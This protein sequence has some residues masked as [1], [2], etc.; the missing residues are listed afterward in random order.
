M[1]F[2]LTPWPGKRTSRLWRNEMLGFYFILYLCHTVAAGITWRIVEESKVGTLV[3]SLREVT[4][5]FKSYDLVTSS[6]ANT[7]SN[8]VYNKTTGNV[9][10]RQIIDSDVLPNQCI[11][12]SKVEKIQFISSTIGV[13][14]IYVDV[15]IDD[16]NDNRPKFASDLFTKTISEKDSKGS[17]VKIP[18]AQDIDCGSNSALQY[19]ILNSNNF[20]IGLTT[21][22][23][24]DIVSE[25]EL[26]R[27]LKEFH[28]L[29]I[30]A[31]DHGIPSKCSSA[32]INITVADYNDNKPTFHNLK[33]KVNVEEKCNA[34]SKFILALNVSDKDSGANGQ[35]TLS[36]PHLPEYSHHFDIISNNILV[37]T[38]CLTYKKNKQCIHVKINAVD[39]GVPEQRND[40]D[41]CIVVQD[42]NDHDP[43]LTSSNTKR[44]IYE[45]TIITDHVSI[46]TA[47][48]EDG[49]Q[50]AYV[51]LNIVAG[52]P[53]NK[54]YLRKNGHFFFLHLNGTLDREEMSVYNITIQG[55]DHGIPPRTSYISI[56]IPVLDQNDNHPSCSFPDAT[57][58]LKESSPIGTFVT[59][60]QIMDKDKGNNSEITY[61]LPDSSQSA[62][63][64][65]IA[66]S[67]LITTSAD[68]DYETQ[69]SITLQVKVED[70]GN[71]KLT[72]L[73]S[74]TINITDINDNNP[75]FTNTTFHF[76]VL[77]NTTVNSVVANVSSFDADTSKNSKLT[78]S[79]LSPSPVV[80]RTF[81]MNSD[82][83]AIQTLIALD[84]E[85]C[86]FYQFGVLVHD[87]GNPQLFSTATVNLAILDINDNKPVF[88]P[89]H[90]YI[91][92]HANKSDEFIVNVMAMDIDKNDAIL[93]KIVGQH[94]MNAL[95]EVN[96]KT[97]TVICNDMSQLNAN[98][99]FTV[100]LTAEDVEGHVSNISTLYVTVITTDNNLPYFETDLYSFN[101]VENIQHG[102]YVGEVKATSKIHGTD[103]SYSI[104][105]GDPDGIFFINEHGEIRTS[106]DVDHEKQSLFNLQVMGRTSGRRVLITLTSVVITVEDVNDNPP[107]FQYP[108]KLITV[109]S[110]APV[111][112]I[113]FKAR[114]LDPDSSDGGIVKYGLLHGSHQDF[115]VLPGGDIIV[116]NDLSCALN[117]SPIIRI[118]ASDSGLPQLSSVLNLT[119]NIIQEYG[120]LPIIHKN[121]GVIA[122][123]QTAP[124]NKVFFNMSD[125]NGCNDGHFYFYLLGSTKATDFFGIFPEGNLYVKQSLALTAQLDFS[126]QV[127]VRDKNNAKLNSTSFVQI[128]VVQVEHPQ[129]LFG[130]DV[131]Q[132]SV[133]ENEYPGTIVG[134]LDYV[135]KFQSLEVNFM[136]EH[137]YF[138]FDVATS[139]IKTK[140]HI[141]REQLIQ[142]MGCDNFVLFAKASYKNSL[143]FLVA[144]LAKIVVEV[145][146][147]NDNMPTC[148]ESNYMVN[149][150]E[151]Q[152]VGTVILELITS[153][154][155]ANQNSLVN[156]SIVNTSLPDAVTVVDGGM[157][158]LNKPLENKQIFYFNFSV[159]VMNIVLPYYA[160]TCFIEVKIH[161]VNNNKPKFSE[162]F[163]MR[164]VAENATIG[165]VIHHRNAVDND[166]GRNSRL[167]YTIIS[168]NQ[169]NNF[170]IDYESGQV[171]LA[172][173]LDFEKIQSYNLTILARDS[174]IWPLYNHQILIVNVTDVND[175]SPHFISCPSLLKLKENTPV[176]SVVLQCLA[177]DRDTG[178]NGIVHYS[179]SREKPTDSFFR[180]NNNGTLYINK[181]LDREQFPIYKVDITVEDGAMPKASRL[182]RTKTITIELEDVN[183]NSP[184]FISPSAAYFYESASTG[185]YVTTLKAWDPD[186]GMNGRF[187]FNKVSGKDAAFF[188]V[189]EN[190]RVTF[191]KQP[192]RILYQVNVLVTDNGA[193][194]KTSEQ[195]LSVFMYKDGDLS[196]LQNMYSVGIVENE[197]VGTFVVNV[198]AASKMDT[199]DNT[200][201]Q[202][203][204]TSDSSEGLLYLN[205]STGVITIKDKID[206]EGK[207]GHQINLVIYA[208]QANKSTSVN[209]SIVIFDL[210]DNIPTFT[211]YT[212]T[213]SIPENAKIGSAV[214]IVLAFDEDA[215]RNGSLVYDIVGGNSKRAFLISNVTGKISVASNLDREIQSMYILNVTATDNG[216]P[217]LSS[218]TIVSVNILDINDN[219]PSFQRLN[220]S[221]TVV[222]NSPFGTIIGQT[223][224]RDLDAGDNGQL[225]YSLNG[226]DANLFTVNAKTGTIRTAVS[227]DREKIDFYLFEIV[228][229]DKGIPKTLSTMSLVYVNVLDQNDNS[230]KFDLNRS[231]TATVPESSLVGTPIITVHASDDDVGLNSVLSYA[232]TGGDNDKSFR[233][234]AR[235]TLLT[236]SV[237][238]RENVAKYNIEVTVSDFANSPSN[239][240]SSK[241]TVTVNVADINDNTPYFVSEDV[242]HVRED[243]VLGQPFA[244]V[245]ARDKDAGL[246]GKIVYKLQGTQTYF[247]IDK[248]SGELGLAR[249]LDREKLETGYIN[250]TVEVKDRGQPPKR[251]Q[252]QVQ[253]IVDDVNDNTPTFQ[254]HLKALNVYENISIG[255]ELVRVTA[256]DK[257]LGPNGKVE[258]AITGGN[259]NNSFSI[260]PI[261][262]VVTLIKPLDRETL[263]NYQ[264]NITAFDFGSPV[265][266]NVTTVHIRILDV[267]DNEPRFKHSPSVK[268]VKENIPYVKTL[269]Q[270]VATDND[271]GQNSEVVYSILNSV[272]YPFFSIDNSTGVISLVAPLDREV[273]TTYLLLIE[274]RDKGNPPLYTQTELTITVKDENDNSPVFI[275]PYIK[276]SIVE[277][278]AVGS[279]LCV[280]NATDADDSNANAITYELDNDLGRFRIDS[281]TGEIF[282]TAVLDR[283]RDGTEFELTV[284]AT[285]SGSPPRKTSTT[286]IGLIEDVDDNRAKFES[287]TYSAYIP[288]S[289]LDGSFVTVVSAVDK[290]E[291]LN[292]KVIYK[293]E[294][295]SKEVRV[296]PYTGNVLMLRRPSFKK[297]AV[298]IHAVNAKSNILQ[299]T[300]TVDITTTNKHFPSFDIPVTV[301]NI[302]E[303]AKRGY[304][305][306]NVKATDN[307]SFQIA[308]GDPDKQF[309]LDIISKNLTLNKNLDY[310]KKRQYNLWLK[311]SLNTDYS[312]YIKIQIFVVDSN[313]N[314]PMFEHSHEDVSLIEND[315]KNVSVTCIVAEDRDSG[316]FGMVKYTILERTALNWFKID[317]RTGCIRTTRSI[318]REQNVSFDFT[319]QAQDHGLPAKANTV[320]VH[321]NIVDRNDNA[322]V[323]DKLSPIYISEDKLPPSRVATVFA[324]DRDETSELTYSLE[325]QGNFNDTFT[326]DKITGELFLMKQLDR[327]MIGR[328][329]LTA[330]VSDGTFS[331]STS[332]TVI[333]KDVDDNPPKFLK[334]FYQIK[335]MELQ[336]VGSLVLKLN[337][338]DKDIGQNSDVVYSLKRTPTS[339]IFRIDSSGAITVATQLRYVKPTKGSAPTSLYNLTVY[340]RNPNHPSAKPT[341]TITVEIT[342]VND[343]RPVFERNEYY[344][345]IPNVSKIGTRIVAVYAIDNYDVGLNSEVSYRA[346]GGN[347]TSLFSVEPLTGYVT[348]D[349]DISSETDKLFLLEIQAYDRGTPPQNTS[350]N[351]KVFITVTRENRYPPRLTQRKY[352]KELRENYEV[353]K[354]FL[355]V[356][357]TDYD[358]GIN[359]KVTYTILPGRQEK[360]FNIDKNTGSITIA[361]VKLDYEYLTEYS[362]DIQA[363]DGAQDPRTD[364]ATVTITV[365]DYNDNPPEFQKSI[366]NV[367]VPEN[368]EVG[369][370][371]AV[372]SATD[373]DTVG[374]TITYALTDQDKKIFAIDENS[375]IIT[376]K[377][378]FDYESRSVFNITVLARDSAHPQRTSDCVVHVKIQGI[379]EYAPEFKEKEYLFSIP[380]NVPVGTIV[381]QV[382]AT[383][384][385]DGPDGVVQFMF[386]DPTGHYNNFDVDKFTGNVYVYSPLDFETM[387]VVQLTVLVKN[388]SQRILNADNT[389][390]ANIT[391]QIEDRNDPPRFLQDFMKVSV[392]EN[393][394]VGS[395]LGNLTAVDNDAKKHFISPFKYTLSNGD[396]H[397][398][399]ALETVGKTAILKTNKLLDREVIA[400]YNLTIAA[401]DI[402]DPSLHDIAHVIVEL[403]DINDNPPVLKSGIC[404]GHI[405]EN[406]KKGSVV[407]R[408]DASDKDV[409]PNKDPYTFE[410]ENMEYVPF[411]I[412]KLTSELKTS[413]MLDREKVPRYVVKIKIT[414]SGYPRQSSTTTCNVFVDDVNDNRPSGDTLNVKINIPATGY[415]G[416][417]IS[418]VSPLDLDEIKEYTCEVEGNLKDIFNFQPNSCILNIK[419]PSL[420]RHILNVIARDSLHTVSYSLNISFNRI[421]ETARASSIILRLSGKSPEQFLTV[422]NH[423]PCVPGYETKIFSVQQV[424]SSVTDVV[425]AHLQNGVYI[426]RSQLSQILKNC[427]DSLERKLEANIL[428]TNYDTCLSSNPCI[429]GKCEHN[430]I[431]SPQNHTSLYSGTE[432]FVS[433]S[434]KASFRCICDSG[435]T[436]KYCQYSTKICE[437]VQCKNTG[438]CIPTAQGFKC[439][440]PLNFTGEFCGDVVNLCDPNPCSNTSKCLSTH[441][442]PKCQ[443]D[444]GGRGERCEW[445]SF[446]FK[447]LAYMTLPSLSS[448]VGKAD[449]NIS[450]QIATVERNALILYNADDTN[451]NQD[452]SFVALEI[453]NG[454][455][456]YSFN[457]GYGAVHI[458]SD[459]IV[460]DGNWHIISAVRDKQVR[461]DMEC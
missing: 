122:L 388:P 359:G 228:A 303:D 181:P 199:E 131:F 32:I 189:E 36:V 377:V 188:N 99:V 12:G 260:H 277:G 400:L 434:H 390:I 200:I 67:G 88:Y 298:K 413:E 202:Y 437:G 121:F 406:L 311:A 27:E 254:T 164:R 83:G 208:L 137:A 246:N 399:F 290:D 218:W 348:V 31:C 231:Y 305:I 136:E 393:V 13:N 216:Q 158:V 450:L 404:P 37:S 329:P 215:E 5:N 271:E 168:G 415:H 414:D 90:Y 10:T 294:G 412:N 179:I 347:G 323:L 184:R 96:Q 313:D 285:D 117:Y 193:V 105:S 321:I 81:Y 143:G 108:Q 300:T 292:G 109:K 394:P 206:R 138:K 30:S 8:F 240:L 229:R 204:M 360:Y 106:A 297:Y 225:T 115:S 160:S 139:E 451:T 226:H 325:P 223:V 94:P 68:L 259:W 73:C 291:G 173:K 191:A 24:L 65:I 264:I 78:F 201:I 41:L 60:V 2:S 97:G 384:Q 129:Q 43:V 62:V 283:E 18:I 365:T 82:T 301:Y 47:D 79:I 66:S 58:S 344:Q 446:G 253:I 144:D 156:F 357:A 326:V 221:F 336:P 314:I 242:I 92:I 410:I 373:R 16:I 175:N 102:T 87:N 132:F 385:D 420:E 331:D 133:Y 241:T 237:L 177:D 211:N 411:V 234:S 157:I 210:N 26:D 258:Y 461:T 77:E 203:F 63:F 338:S 299:N 250:I 54:F 439:L 4:A 53:N 76:N 307:P 452:S 127:I 249:T 375:G 282:T 391:I 278:S 159:Q 187:K 257:D 162:P 111:G 308:S 70:N 378:K 320:S 1:K 328:Y 374:K 101:I 401:T 428:N 425:M 59:I 372:V 224:A 125:P 454:L 95:F 371:V 14:N 52:D 274:A 449:H 279:R 265:Q 123:L 395:I 266:E 286:F 346:V 444:F 448:I 441:E 302:S 304:F 382:S 119:I 15:I 319:V 287:K 34:G 232:I 370:E 11:N 35:V 339:E 38:K 457:M 6:I 195:E 380:E 456:R 443:C 270:F 458:T 153:D 140:Q 51:S 186:L 330:T 275:N 64:N 107:E 333:I 238:D 212:Y 128:S 364:K 248:D 161:D 438:R 209:V 318:D 235:G 19:K 383:D 340:G 142:I 267:N 147:R 33:L 386:V 289:A 460:S 315:N 100:N 23:E 154:L 251:N 332:L 280:M 317:G 169:E 44:G 194:P 366:Y 442:G 205:T 306:L 435:Y 316:V 214:L 419:K 190:G 354:E 423:L 284:K 276:P 243:Q 192:T 113:V 197:P 345:Y 312:S 150:K 167:S 281:Q 170:E 389:D 334:S 72:S 126:L 403:R 272:Q 22:Q 445:S 222:E 256:V 376:S 426:S 84:R 263:Q 407:L 50:N 196:F 432:I 118:V 381:G 424:N 255:S 362:F 85:V 252:R 135:A 273:Q 40:V 9:N 148:E 355:R 171:I 327:E 409:D 268:S 379:N 71:P 351:V 429:H 227:F 207:H 295:G 39:H 61:S 176:D 343:H 120:E 416:G 75:S 93:Y 269:A 236:A 163:V 174:G 21:T 430:I 431:L 421:S 459:V 98:D 116:A 134:K 392:P 185:D 352:S 405:R 180:I 69:T 408:F 7:D 29:N 353:G 151:T 166:Y 350:I 440:C 178:E 288:V 146:D 114:A 124:V 217:K 341:A 230:P 182:M 198:T 447:P 309:L 28:I 417:M 56:I 155:D 25:K 361:N 183:D 262:G 152:R 239:R 245:L 369:S 293:I 387:D 80:E 337:I 356:V 74:L 219:I 233:I 220:Y 358:S 398:S 103:I 397:Q 436:G 427:K 244:S 213:E 145:K 455:L 42:I 367:D 322:P 261:D 368:K 104:F 110:K 45:N 310:E 165:Q 349:S 433:A 17:S 342:D 324:N 149:I 57:I 49:G 402:N 453:T 55:S 91:N 418:D 130:K 363:K 48:D 247:R 141:D 86:D 335:F 3:G 46:I 89:R 112:S 422:M 296:E 172:R 20:E 396:I